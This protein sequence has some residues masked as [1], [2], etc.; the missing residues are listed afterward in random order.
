[1]KLFTYKLG[2]ALAFGA[3]S[4]QSVSAQATSALIQVSAQGRLQYMPDSRGGTVPD[5]SA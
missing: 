1:M 3:L 2:A 5:F 4:S